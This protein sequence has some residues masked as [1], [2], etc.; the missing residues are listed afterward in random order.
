MRKRGFLSIALAAVLTFSLTSC[1][2]TKASV[3]DL[4][5][6]I[7]PA[8]VE[9]PT[10]EEAF[11]SEQAN[12]ATEL[13]ASVSDG[14]TNTLISPLSVA[15]ALGMAANGAGGETL[16]EFE[17]LFGG[18]SVDELNRQFAS[19]TAS[20]TNGDKYKLDIANSIWM[21]N[22]DSLA[23]KDS[24]LQAGADYFDADAF[25]IDINDGAV[26]KIN[27]WVSE[28]TDGMIEK[29]IDELDPATVM[30]LINTVLFDAE[31]QDVYTERNLT[32]GTFTAS[33]GE[34]REVTM[35]NS[36]ESTYIE[37]ENA[38]GFI[39]NYEKGK[40]KFVALLPNEDVSLSELIDSLD[41][42]SLIGL[43]KNALKGCT[44]VAKLPKFEYDYGIELND[45]LASMGLTDAFSPEEAD[46]S[47]ISDR[48]E[49]LM[50]YISRVLHKSSIVVGPQGT[51]AA[52]A[53]TM[54]VLCGS[55][56]PTD[57]KYVTLDRPFMYMIIDGTTS[58]PI[59]MGAV[60]DIGK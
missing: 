60:T 16:E 20:L 27:E 50:L 32:E 30:V 35:M 23:V 29:M 5:S 12:F 59:F 52:A 14:K 58:L 47:G 55:A 7:K 56:A 46:F 49:E 51:K 19:L 44:V 38:T 4:M 34:R 3:T 24:F 1:F 10:G 26:K 9:K 37:T 48:A 41:G 22:D 33:N 17:S 45:I 39:K 8:A 21:K 11:L 54:E 28:N 57:I 15:L 6:G 53:T 36:T 43:S 31:W 42:E 13:F 40:Y 25:K 18:M 2:F